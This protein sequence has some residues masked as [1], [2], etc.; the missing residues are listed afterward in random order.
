MPAVIAGVMDDTYY[1]STLHPTPGVLRAGRAVEQVQKYFSG[2]HR[3]PV[4]TLTD[5]VVHV[6]VIDDMGEI[7][8]R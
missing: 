8:P 1:R 5:T 6:V 2:S 7:V 3:R 4:Q